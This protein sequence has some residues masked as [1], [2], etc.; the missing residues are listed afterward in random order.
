[1]PGQRSTCSTER[2]G[3]NLTFLKLRTGGRD[4]GYL[5]LTFPQKIAP[6]LVWHGV[7]LSHGAFPLHVDVG[8]LVLRVPPFAEL[9]RAAAFLRHQNAF[10]HKGRRNRRVTF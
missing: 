3:A 1:M 2:H 7:G 6:G 5:P 9:T 8:T 10:L 4:G